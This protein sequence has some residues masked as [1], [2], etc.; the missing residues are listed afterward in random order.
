MLTLPL[1]QC[2]LDITDTA[3]R[4]AFYNPVLHIGHTRW[5]DSELTVTVVNFIGRSSAWF[6]KIIDHNIALRSISA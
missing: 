3:K 4:Y 1:E 2:D 5:Y 6:T